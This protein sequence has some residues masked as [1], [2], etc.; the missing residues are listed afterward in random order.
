MFLDEFLGLGESSLF[1][2]NS[3]DDVDMSQIEAI[4]VKEGEDPLEACLRITLENEQNYTNII[5]TIA[6]SE[7]AAL[8]ESGGTEVV[9]EAVDI[10]KIADTVF[11]WIR[12]QWGK[13]KGVFQ[14]ALQN[15][16]T[17][18]SNDKKL[19]KKYEDNKA[20]IKEKSVTVKGVRIKRGM[21]SLA[22]TFGDA[23]DAEFNSA[24]NKI[25]LSN[26]GAITPD[27]AKAISSEYSD[28]K[29]SMLRTAMSKVAGVNSTMAD[30]SKNIKK[31]HCEI[32]DITI[33]AEIAYSYVKSGKDYVNRV[34]EEFSSAEKEFK[35]ELNAAKEMKKDYKGE[36]HS[37]VAK[38]IN[39][40]CAQ[41][42]TKIM[43]VNLLSRTAIQICNAE[44]STYKKALV[45]V[46]SKNN[47]EAK[48]DDKKTATGESA[49]ICDLI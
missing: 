30:F 13:L 45:T 49:L 39:V 19:V 38:V 43:H 7:L 26:L 8:E 20:K 11:E 15:I 10:K 14:R 35:K 18:L 42:K 28:K 23:L 27:K 40:R 6:L 37:A 9:Y 25:D 46:L 31:A 41:I 36:N 5:S 12:T 3:V 29:D 32:G 16:K 2:N 48:Q 4:P 21:L 44:Y 33:D 24:T 22:K 34:K 47:I 1:G 17:M